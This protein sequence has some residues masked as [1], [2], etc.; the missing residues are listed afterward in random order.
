MKNLIRH[1]TLLFI[2][3]T[4]PGMIFAQATAEK[5]G[6]IEWHS[7]A[8][9]YKMNKKKPKKLFIDVYTD[10]CG[11]CKKM[12]RE[13]FLDPETAKYMQKHF[14]C[15]KLNAETKDTIV[16]DDTV[17]F[18]NS[19]PKG[20]GGNNQ[21][22]VEL[23]KGKMSYPSYVF[24]NEKNQYLIM[25]PGYYSAADFAPFIHY[26]G[27]NTYQNTKWE[28]YL[29]ALKKNSDKKIPATEPGKKK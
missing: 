14:Y 23:L 16:I 8:E 25:I 29:A 10:W 7:F 24:L 5:S 17:K 11:W 28:D 19:N 21:L 15:V 20:K 9:A 13:T 26:F 1:Y 18:V 3:I 22:A 12:D 6:I 27:D 2:V 4:L